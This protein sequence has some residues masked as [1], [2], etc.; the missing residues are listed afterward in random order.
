M[1]QS[2]EGVRTPNTLWSGFGFSKSMPDFSGRNKRPITN[3]GSI[4]EFLETDNASISNVEAAAAKA[5]NSDI[6]EKNDSPLEQVSSPFALSN[7]WENLPRAPPVNYSS[8]KSLEQLLRVL[9]LEKYGD[10]FVHHEIDLP[11]F[12]T[13]N[14]IE[15]QQLNISYGAR[16]KMLNAIAAIREQRLGDWSKDFRA[17]PGAERK[18]FPRFSGS[19]APNGSTDRISKKRENFISREECLL[20]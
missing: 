7:F 14:E 20:Y 12:L 18:T 11:I 10:V 5:W 16:R 9:D 1:Q 19:S 17:A 13:L 8:I 3:S 15:L 6:Q 2:V 4:S